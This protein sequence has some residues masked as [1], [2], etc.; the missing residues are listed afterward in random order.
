MTRLQLQSGQTMTDDF[1]VVD[2]SL[3]DPMN[4]GPGKPRKYGK[5]FE[6]LIDGKTLRAPAG[7]SINKTATAFRVAMRRRGYI[8]HTRSHKAENAVIVWAEKIRE[9]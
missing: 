7:W 2:D 4:S 5:V 6:D 9:G 3:R 8:V 1:E